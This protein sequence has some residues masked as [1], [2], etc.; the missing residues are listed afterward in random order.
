MVDSDIIEASD[1]NGTPIQIGT[2]VK[3]INSD[4][5]GI[6]TDIKKD[7]EGVWALVDAKD[8]YYKVETLIVLEK[9]VTKIREEK[10][11]QFTAND[12]AEYIKNVAESMG[13]TDVKGI[14]GVGGG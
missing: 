7:A 2:A 10:E 1:I 12:A 8:L 5:E 14:H 9:S 6:V 13:S 3:Y 11:R 4:T